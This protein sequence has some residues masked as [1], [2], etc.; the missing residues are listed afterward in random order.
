M[1]KPIQQ[2]SCFKNYCAKIVKNPLQSNE[3]QTICV[4]GL[5]FCLIFAAS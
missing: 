2:R 3:K 1:I 5:D 4:L